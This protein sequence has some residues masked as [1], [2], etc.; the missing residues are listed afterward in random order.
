MRCPRRAS[1]RARER[2]VVAWPLP[3]E[4]VTARPKMT[5]FTRRLPSGDLRGGLAR[6]EH[7][8]DRGGSLV[9]GVVAQRP[10]PHR[11]ANGARLLRRGP[12][13]MFDDLFGR[14][15]REYFPSGRKEL[16]DAGPCVGDQAR[17]RAGCFK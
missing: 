6:M 13:Q 3:Q 4:E 16:L 14:G 17:T 10:L 8:L 7:R 11:F 1:A 2:K 5:M 12:A 15:C 9:I